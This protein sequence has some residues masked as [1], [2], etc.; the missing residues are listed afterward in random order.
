MKKYLLVIL[1]SVIDYYLTS[2]LGYIIA[3]Y[4]YLKWKLLSINNL[5]ILAYFI[6]LPIVLLTWLLIKKYFSE[7]KFNQTKYPKFKVYL[8]ALFPTI[9]FLTYRHIINDISYVEISNYRQ[10]VRYVITYLFLI[11]IVE[12]LIYRGIMFRIIVNKN[13]IVVS[14]IIISFLFMLIHIDSN[15]IDLSYLFYIFITGMVLF[16]VRLNNGLFNSIVVHSLINLTVYVF[17]LLIN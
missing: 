10:V 6:K 13:N 14:S 7:T 15:N 1:I 4:V 8:I 17:Q 5:L 9:I 12:E 2:Y 11:P 3:T 16:F